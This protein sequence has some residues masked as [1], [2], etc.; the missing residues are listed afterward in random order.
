MINAVLVF[1]NAGQPRLTKF[2]TQL[3]TSVQ[4]RL[5]S[6]IF[7]LVANRPSS[8]CN[9]LPNLPSP[10]P[11]DSPQRHPSLVTYR[12]YATLYFIVISTSTESPLALLDLIQVFVQALDGLFEN[13]CELDLIFNF[14]TL[15]AALGE[16]I[17]GGV[18]VETQLDRVIEGSRVRAGREEASQRGQV[19][20]GSSIGRG[21]GLWAGR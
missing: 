15:H 10:P 20:G 5:I 7:T 8:A 1:N 17:V 9:F 13:V 4:Q 19:W 21:G 18:V 6:E 16:M 11:L 14:E 3:E 2:Y 12:H